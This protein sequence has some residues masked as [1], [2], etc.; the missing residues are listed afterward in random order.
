[1]KTACSSSGMAS[2][3]SPQATMQDAMPRAPQTTDPQG[4]PGQ[5]HTHLLVVLDAHAQRVDENGYHN[6]SVEILAF[7][8][9]FQLAAKSLPQAGDLI[10]LLGFFLLLPPP[11]PLLLE[12]ISVVAMP[13]VLGELVDAIAVRV[14]AVGLA[15]GELGV[16]QE[17]GTEGTVLQLTG[18]CPTRW[19]GQWAGR[20]QP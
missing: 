3:E 20:A 12:L 6:P 19:A 9:P 16:F 13:Q 10:P 14:A 15:E 7:H 18:Q 8:D 4:S 1:M 5:T 11:A 2:T 17:A